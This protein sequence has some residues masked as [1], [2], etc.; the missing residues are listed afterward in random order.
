MPANPAPVAIAKP[1]DRRRLQGRMR[2]LAE[3]AGLMEERGYL[4]P[5]PEPVPL[6]RRRA[7]ADREGDR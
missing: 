5:A 6:H 1:A 2:E 4:P 7:N 3:L